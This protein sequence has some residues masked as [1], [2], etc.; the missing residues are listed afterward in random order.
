MPAPSCALKHRAAFTL[1]ELLV[2]SALLLVLTSLVM[3][4][5][6][7]ALNC[8]TRGLGQSELMRQ[9]YRAMDSLTRDLRLCPAAVLGYDPAGH[10]L[11]G[12]HQSG[13]TPDGTCLYTA[14]C[15]VYEWQD[16][17]QR[18]RRGSLAI[19]GAAQDSLV[20]PARIGPQELALALPQASWQA[21]CAG[22]V[23]FEF[24]HQG[25]DASAPSGS[26]DIHLNLRQ[27]SQHLELSQSVTPRLSL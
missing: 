17:P 20:Q 7:P 10:R 15:W 26:Y 9:G 13:W 11:V 18:L 23:G 22:V 16:Q 2:A 25:L 1:P 27:G 3:D 6:V 21:L 12:R 8:Q 14:R 5:F 24:S 19:G 4:F